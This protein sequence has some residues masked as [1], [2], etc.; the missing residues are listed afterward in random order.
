[1]TDSAA[2][3]PSKLASFFK[4]LG[5]SVL[6]CAILWGML[7][8]LGHIL[9]PKGNSKD[10]GLIESRAYGF[11]A[12]PDDSLDA[13]FLGDSL[14]STGFSPMRIWGDAGVASFVCSVNVEQVSYAYTMLRDVFKTQKPQVVF[15]ETEML[16]NPFSVG[17]VFKQFVKDQFT[18][19]EYH[20]RWKELTLEDFTGQVKYDKVSN[21]KGS[22]PKALCEP[23]DT[24]CYML[25]SDEVELPGK[26]NLVFLRALADL[27]EENGAQFVLVATPHTRDWNYARHNGCAQI[28]QDLGI[29][30]IDMNT[31]PIASEVGIDWSHDA[32]DA[33]IHLN[34]HGMNKVSDWMASYL[35]ET[36]GL[37]DHRGDQAYA[38]WGKC[39]EEY[40]EYMAK[41]AKDPEKYDIPGVHMY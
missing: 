35:S 4:Y 22:N 29:D 5:L 41:V 28:A 32:R 24:S 15:L 12:E 21:L 17:K 1:M 13:V 9:Q 38:R 39:L 40:E 34:Y 23:A 3:K 27:C 36:L 30:F 14:A 33:G 10:D 7:V 25:P 37:P 11:L 2:P 19:A 18:V 31:E 20:H 6:F 16:Y 26:L 8:G